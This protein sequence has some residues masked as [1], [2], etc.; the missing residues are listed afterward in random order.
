MDKPRDLSAQ[1]NIVQSRNET[2]FSHRLP[3]GWIQKTR[4]EINQTQK[5]KHCMIDSTYVRYLEF[6]FTETESRKRVPAE[7]WGVSL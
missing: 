1:W 6:K 4:R 7:E 2:K 5:N 3:D